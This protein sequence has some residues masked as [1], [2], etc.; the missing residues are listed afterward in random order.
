MLPRHHLLLHTTRNPSLHLHHVSVVGP[1]SA[2]GLVGSTCTNHGSHHNSGTVSVA[3]VSQLQ[4]TPQPRTPRTCKTPWV[5]H[6]QI[7]TINASVDTSA[8]LVGN[9][10]CRSHV[11]G[12]EEESHSHVSSC[13]C[14]VKVVKA[15]QIF[16]FG[17]RLV[18]QEVLKCKYWYF[19][20]S[21]QIWTIGLKMTYWENSCKYYLLIIYLISLNN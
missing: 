18:K 8:L 1:P 2:M 13:H 20:M 17:Q 10:H 14:T 19:W 6:H 7:S 11:T 4:H 5:T 16:K 21:L 15:G 3:I 9:L 12:E